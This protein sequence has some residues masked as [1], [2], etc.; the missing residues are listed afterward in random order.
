MGT[1]VYNGTGSIPI[2]DRLL[3]HL[4][5]V[6]IDKLRRQESF[7]FSWEVAG[8]ESTVWFGPSIALEFVYA[9]NRSPLLN[10]AW[11]NQLAAA[12]SS[13]AGL[14]ALPEP[15]TA[16]ASA[17][18]ASVSPPSVTPPT[19]PLADPAKPGVPVGV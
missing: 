4:Q 6:I 10:R 11:L 1:L 15:L 16:P 5:V 12:A 3:A 18:A 17:A 2:D 13:N 7:P 14:S 8:R 9:G 19:A